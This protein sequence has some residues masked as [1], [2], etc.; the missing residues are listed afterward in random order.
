[1]TPRTRKTPAGRV[2]RVLPTAADLP[3]LADF[4]DGYLHQD[5]T[6]DYATPA[7]AL[8]ACLSECDGPERAALAAEWQTFAQAVDGLAWREV[9]RAFGTV[10]GTWQPSSQEELDAVFSSLRVR[11]RTTG[12]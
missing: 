4:L 5:F 7:E 8:H 1:M 9:R 6:L 11:S 10:G 2:S 3:H 12:P